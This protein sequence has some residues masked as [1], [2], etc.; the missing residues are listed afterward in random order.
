MKNPDHDPLQPR[1]EAHSYPVI[2]GHRMLI[3]R[4]FP[5]NTFTF[6]PDI[7]NAH[8]YP[9]D[10][11]T[12]GQ[13]QTFQPTPEAA[14][15]AAKD[16]LIQ[17]CG[18]PAEDVHFDPNDK[19]TWSKERL[20]AEIGALNE[21][22]VENQ[23]QVLEQS[24]MLA[25]KTSELQNLHEVLGR[26]LTRDEFVRVFEALRQQVRDEINQKKGAKL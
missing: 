20:L 18:V 25:T 2:A 17:H 7:G 11:L 6:Q 3:V 10:A 9:S 8:E 23:K 16:W 5:A 1:R 22:I 4:H 13:G 24:K 14:L 19:R 15:A 21:V 12:A 26:V